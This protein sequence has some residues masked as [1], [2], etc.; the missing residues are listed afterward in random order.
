MT[1]I[2]K[3]LWNN[4]WRV[5]M[6]EKSIKWTTKLKPLLTLD[7]SKV[8][9]GWKTF[10]SEFNPQSRCSKKEAAMCVCVCVCVCVWRKFRKNSCL[11]KKKKNK[12]LRKTIKLME[13]M[14][15]AY[16]NL[17]LSDGLIMLFPVF[18]T[19]WVSA[20]LPLPFKKYSEW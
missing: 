6:E 17:I 14:N 2:T 4:K 15:A 5:K 11:Q 9:T 8:I 7:L 16:K 10:M 3:W 18:S 12:F 19:L 20:H 1:I 13:P